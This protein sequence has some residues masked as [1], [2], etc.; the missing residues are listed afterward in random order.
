MRT[1]P[2]TASGL[3]DID[4]DTQSDITTQ[5]PL[6][7]LSLSEMSKLS[8]TSDAD[9][10]GLEKLN[11]AMSDPTLRLREPTPRN[12]VKH[13]GS[14]KGPEHGCFSFRH[15]TPWIHNDTMQELQDRGAW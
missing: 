10:Q 13:L 5:K 12:H 6:G 3:R 1:R 2:S 14:W 11:R 9:C 4:E 8:S 15:S 7:Q